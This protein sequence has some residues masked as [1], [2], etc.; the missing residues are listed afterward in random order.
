MQQLQSD[1][2]T[3]ADFVTLVASY[4]VCIMDLDKY[5]HETQ[6]GSMCFHTGIGRRGEGSDCGHGVWEKEAIVDKEYGL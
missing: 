6:G 3:R 2:E 5:M 1:A 4:H